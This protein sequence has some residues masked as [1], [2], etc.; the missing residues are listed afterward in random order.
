MAMATLTASRASQG[1]VGDAAGRVIR[2]G[3]IAYWLSGALALAAAGSSLATFLVAGVLR[4]TAVMNG[5]ARGT[6]LVV[7]LVGVPLLA[8]SMWAAARGSARAL[9]TW[10]GTAAFLLYNSLMF[11]FATP[12]NRLFLLYVAMLSL[13]AWSVATVVWQADARALAGRFSPRVPVRGIAAYMWAV[14][15]LNAAAWL[16]RIVPA[17]V[18]SGAPAYLRGTGLTTNVVYVQDLALWLPLLAVAAAWLWRHRPWGYLI[19]GAGLVM[20]VL[21]SVSIA[22]NQWYGHAADPGSPVASGVLVPAFAVLALAGLV[23][24][25]YLLRG[26]TSLPPGTA[27]GFAVPAASR[28]T[29]PAWVLAVVT[30]MV[31]V[32]AL[33]G[34]TQLLRNGFGMPL[35]WLS[36]TPFTSWALPGLALLIGVAIPQLAALALITASNRW[37]LA[38]SY[39]AGMALVAWILVQLLV[40]QRYFFLQPALAGIGALEVLLAW[41]WHHT[42]PSTA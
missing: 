41:A 29:W 19:A 23:P 1:L 42:A 24:I 27:P 16:A 39:M 35:S 25:Y 14:V 15:V 2:R 26:F 36:H 37:A 40:L 32:G 4:G 9:L 34:G 20:W 12:V 17:L 5:S 33:F 8:G 10:L 30:L 13:S 38:V 21:E 3:G 22:V 18:G 7:L 31:G 11:V 28:R 6:S